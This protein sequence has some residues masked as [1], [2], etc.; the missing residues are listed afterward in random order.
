MF[1][2]GSLSGAGAAGCAAGTQQWAIS[3]DRAMGKAI[4][5]ALMQAQ[6]LDKNVQVWGYSPD[7]CDDWGDRMLPSFV[8]IQD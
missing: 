5:A 3:M 7:T 1:Q 2:A 4:L 8:I 6:A